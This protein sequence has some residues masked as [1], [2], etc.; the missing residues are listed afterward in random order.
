MKRL[1]VLVL[2]LFALGFIGHS[3]TIM[4]V[5][6]DS[7]DELA[8]NWNSRHAPHGNGGNGNG[9]GNGKG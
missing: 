7:G 6:G 5:D 1:A 9:N 8:V 3:A 2:M 4:Q